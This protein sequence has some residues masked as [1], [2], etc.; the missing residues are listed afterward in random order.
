[1][2]PVQLY[3]LSGTTRFLIRDK[4]YKHTAHRVP[5]KRWNIR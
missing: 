3:A 1:L 5:D 4:K 2:R